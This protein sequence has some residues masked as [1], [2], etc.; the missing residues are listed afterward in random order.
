LIYRCTFFVGAIEKVGRFLRQPTQTIRLDLSAYL[1]YAP[2]GICL[3]SGR[4]LRRQLKHRR[5]LAHH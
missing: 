5:F 4:W 2:L 3:G 1:G